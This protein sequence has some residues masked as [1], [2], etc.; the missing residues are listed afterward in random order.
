MSATLLSPKSATELAAIFAGLHEQ[1]TTFHGLLLAQREAIRAANPP[2][3]AHIGELQLAALRAISALEDR[4]RVLVNT[5]SDTGHWTG[6]TPITLTSL[7]EHAPKGQNDSLR[8][9]A[10]SLRGVMSACQVEQT[11]LK[12]AAQ[13]LAAH[14]EG[15]MRQIARTL[16]H[17][18]TYGRRGVVDCS[19]A[20]TT[21][22]DLRS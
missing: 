6:P 8:A 2:L 21:A 11:S 14:I 1:Y 9:T 13:S 16:S 19:T 12:A 15:V 18:G 5:V 17:A 7:A 4:R 10:A 3:L 20:V 22:L